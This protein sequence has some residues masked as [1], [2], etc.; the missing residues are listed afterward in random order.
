MHEDKYTG[1]KEDINMQK[2]MQ[3]RKGRSVQEQVQ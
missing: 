3:R 2:K 1:T